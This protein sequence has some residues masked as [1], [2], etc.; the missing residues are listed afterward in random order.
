MHSLNQRSDTDLGALSAT[1]Q[2]SF[3][4]D[5]IIKRTEAHDTLALSAFML[6]TLQ[7]P[8]A[9]KKL[10]KEMWESGAHT[11]VSSRFCFFTHFTP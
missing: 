2:K 5:G 6:S 3:R 11:I 7:T 8:L 10:V 9:K 1:W 4:E